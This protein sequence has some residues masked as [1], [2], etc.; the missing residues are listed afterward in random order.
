MEPSYK[1]PYLDS[2]VYIAAIKGEHGRADTARQ[3]LEAARRGEFEV[4]ASTFLIA[5]VIRDKGQPILTLEQEETIDRFV[6]HPYV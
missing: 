6:F 3:I 4:I 2:S 5:E 1:R